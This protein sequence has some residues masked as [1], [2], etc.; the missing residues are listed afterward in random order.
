M[1]MNTK[2]QRLKTPTKIERH[3]DSDGLYLEVTKSGSKNWRYRY[4]NH[5]GSWTMK[6][7]GSYPK[8][9]LEKARALRDDLEMVVEYKCISFRETASEWLVYKG[10]TSYKNKHLIHRRIESYIVTVKSV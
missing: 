6:A 3:L 7:L 1:L 8:T 9:S 10:Y 5:T 4:K 2:I